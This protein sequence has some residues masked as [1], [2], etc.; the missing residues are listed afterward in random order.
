MTHGSAK[1][2]TV[3][4]RRAFLRIAALG[5]GGAA[6]AAYEAAQRRFSVLPAPAEGRVVEK[7][8]HKEV[9]KAVVAVKPVERVKAPAVASAVKA[10]EKIV[11][12]K[13]ESMVTAGKV[14]IEKNQ[15]TARGMKITLSKGED[16]PAT[17]RDDVERTVLARWQPTANVYQ[18]KG[19]GV[20]F[21]PELTESLARLKACQVAGVPEQVRALAEYYRDLALMTMAR[22]G[23]Y[24]A[25]VIG[26]DQ[27]L[28]LVD[29][30]EVE[31]ARIM[32]IATE[33]GKMQQK[34]LVHTR[35]QEA[36]IARAGT[37]SELAIN[38]AKIGT[39]E[40]DWTNFQ[41]DE[42]LRTLS[43][44]NAM[45]A[46]QVKTAE[47]E[48]VT[49]PIA[50][51][52]ILIPKFSVGISPGMMKHR[53]EATSSELGAMVDLA[54]GLGRS[55]EAM[56][57]LA[58]GRAE[59]LSQQFEVIRTTKVTEVILDQLAKIMG[60]QAEDNGVMEVLRWAANFTPGIF[61]IVEFKDLQEDDV[62]GALVFRSP[63][64]EGQ[65][66]TVNS[67]LDNTMGWLEEVI[68]N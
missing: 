40:V 68:C 24:A 61:R 23:K 25:A 35:A 45:E 2:A 6:L 16:E 43:L 52:P 21:V 44:T 5:V 20:Q 26:L 57:R 51:I 3:T 9:E 38:G 27:A 50:L 62:S 37:M 47:M 60:D 28:Q 66:W 17:F 7:P 55:E 10:P 58:G 63:Y 36:A 32:K 4:S 1:E 22:K 67:R 30:N 39:M 18:D 15:V 11:I 54:L 48:V 59:R 41:V 49:A 42:R 46:E 19:E 8:A 34:S 56:A 65:V 12:T 31:V 29:W 14:V 13:P 64:K 33:V 53:L